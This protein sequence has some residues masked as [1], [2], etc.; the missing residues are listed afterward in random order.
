MHRKADL[1]EAVGRLIALLGWDLGSAR[2]PAGIYQKN[3]FVQLL[4]AAMAPQLAP[5]PQLSMRFE[6]DF[7]EL[8]ELGHGTFG[9]VSEVRHRLDG[10][11]YALKV[12]VLREATSEK[13]L[14]EVQVLSGLNHRNVVRYYAAWVQ[15][16]TNSAVSVRSDDDS[17]SRSLGFHSHQQAT[18]SAK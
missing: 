13:I 1:Q 7:E 12:I 11:A 10:R 3:P 4:S 14:R 16:R 5:A 6:T 2:P 8:R 17:Q 18:P 15:P 9:R